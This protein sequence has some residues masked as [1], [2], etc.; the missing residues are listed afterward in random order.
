MLKT[1]GKEMKICNT[2]KSLVS[3]FELE[4]FPSLPTYFITAPHKYTTPKVKGHLFILNII[5]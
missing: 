4:N 5:S 3:V 2:R 1:I